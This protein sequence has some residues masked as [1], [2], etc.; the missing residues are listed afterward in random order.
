MTYI[1][2]GINRRIDNEKENITELKFV[3]S[4]MK[5]RNKKD[6]NNEWRISDLLFNFTLSNTHTIGVSEE[7]RMGQ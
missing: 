1:L 6:Q 5:Q 2:D 3:L 4:K 7:E